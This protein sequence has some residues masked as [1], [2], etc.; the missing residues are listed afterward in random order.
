ML[1]QA[2]SLLRLHQHQLTAEATEMRVDSK[3]NRVVNVWWDLVCF[4]TVL[5]AHCCSAG[6]GAVAGSRGVCRCLLLA[7]WWWLQ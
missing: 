3:L 4:L 2:G 5:C 7:C 6:G 1:M